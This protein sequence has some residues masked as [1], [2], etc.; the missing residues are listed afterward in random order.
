VIFQ[1]LFSIIQGGTILEKRI[2]ENRKDSSSDA[3]TNIQKYADEAYGK[4]LTIEVSGKVGQKE[5]PKVIGNSRGVAITLSFLID[6]FNHRVGTLPIFFTNIHSG[7]GFDELVW[8]C[9][10]L[11]VELERLY[12]ERIERNCPG[13]YQ[14]ELVKGIAAKV[15]FDYVRF[16][17]RVPLV[18]EF[19]TEFLPLRDEWYDKA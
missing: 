15:L 7:I 10:P 8:E 4:Y 11:A 5:D 16:Y 13:V 2:W 9:Y 12:S 19:N 1:Y 6:G 17:G 14:Y 3:R 18:Y